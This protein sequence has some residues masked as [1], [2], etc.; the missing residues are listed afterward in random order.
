MAA[1]L[2]KLYG[3]YKA[4]R[5]I[6]QGGMGCVYEA[7]HSQIQRRVALKVLSDNLAGDRKLATRFLNEA[8][9]VNI[10]SHPSLVIISD[11]GEQDGIPFIVMEYLD[12]ETLTDRVRGQNGQLMQPGPALLIVRQI[13]SGLD[14]AHAKGIVHRDLKPSNIMIIPD[15]E[16]AD[17]ERVKLLDFGVAKFLDG[18]PGLGSD[19]SSLTNADSRLGTPLFM[20]PEQ[21][22]NSSEVTDRADIYSL[23]VIC[24]WLLSGVHPFKGATDM[25]IIMQHLTAT[26]KPLAELCP[27]TPRPICE[28]VESMLAKTPSERPSAREVINILA[29][30]LKGSQSYNGLPAVAP[31]PAAPAE[32]AQPPAGPPLPVSGGQTASPPALF[33]SA[34]ADSG[35]N[36]AV[37]RE[38]GI[39]LPIIIPAA[40]PRI[41]R[42]PR[43]DPDSTAKS[44]SVIGALGHAALIAREAASA[45]QKLPAAQPQPAT[46][47]PAPQSA[48]LARTVAIIIGL[49]VVGGLLWW[50]VLANR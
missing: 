33:P 2:P 39:K 17:G 21:C 27:S 45:S 13:A 40:P 14:A 47:A 6:G 43:I 19:H 35:A 11:V 3:P 4:I 7:L 31:E 1:G 32:P 26:A 28:L 29:P 46:P 23:G 41:Q 22:R 37:D 5:L 16:M 49:L 9:A 12:G 15:P 34:A 20:S 8:R 48:S 42:H 30:L 24:Y 44:E 18:Q 38:L 50:F 36:K 25:A 10:V